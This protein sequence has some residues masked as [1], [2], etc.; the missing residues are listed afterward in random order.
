MMDHKVVSREEWI[1]ARKALLD[2]EKSLTRMRDQ[3]AAERRALPWVRVEKAYEFDTPDGRKSLADLFNGRSQLFVQHFMLAPAQTTQCVGCSFEAD[4]LQP[5][6]VHLRNHDV[7]LVAVARAPLAE[8]EELRQRMGWHFPFVSS[9]GSDFNYDFNVSFTPEQVAAKRA[10][11]NFQDIDP[12]MEDLHGNS[13]FYRDDQ[14]QIFHT[15]SAYGRGAESL[16]TTY[17][18]LDMTPNGRNEKGDLT[19]WV[20]P[21]TMYGKGGM[22]EPNGRYH[23]PTCGCSAHV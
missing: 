8:I 21:S 7:S 5:A 22:V 19:D 4:H 12:G 1:E 16:L 11:Y 15:Y 20:R 17:V 18:V 9:Y 10:N 14:G 6:F 2:G 23:A 13:V 3:I